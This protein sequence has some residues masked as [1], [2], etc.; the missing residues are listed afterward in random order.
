MGTQGD[1]RFGC[2]GIVVSGDI[3]VGLSN[4]SLYSWDWGS[5]MGQGQRLMNMNHEH[6]EK[7]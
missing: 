5:G 4:R 3:Q 6:G 7:Q 2:V 1:F